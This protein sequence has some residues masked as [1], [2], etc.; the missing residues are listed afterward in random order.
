LRTIRL[1]LLLVLALALEAC[2][3]TQPLPA[4]ETFRF[5]VSSRGTGGE[6]TI[7]VDATADFSDLG[8][9]IPL[10]DLTTADEDINGVRHI[11]VGL[12]RPQTA[13]HAAPTSGH[14]E[15]RE[16][17]ARTI[18]L[19]FEYRGHRDVYSLVMLPGGGVRLDPSSGEF[20]RVF[21]K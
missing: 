9:E 5:E 4:G 13:R 6:R 15:F 16:M 2:T 1:V 8:R 21:T 20:S 7:V 18:E 11:R 17:A 12:L 3:T 14:I 10:D 19:V